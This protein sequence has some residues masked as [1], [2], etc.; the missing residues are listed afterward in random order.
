MD[1][2]AV[3]EHQRGALFHVAVQVVAVDVGLQLVGGEHHDDVG[4][5]GGLGHLHDLE[6]LALGLGH[7]LGALA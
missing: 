7:A 6:L 2:E 5:L 1:V 3:R 4:P